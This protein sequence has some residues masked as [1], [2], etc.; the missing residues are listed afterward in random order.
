MIWD[1]LQGWWQGVKGKAREGWD[2]LTDHDLHGG[3]RQPVLAGRQKRYG[4]ERDEVF[5]ATLTRAGSAT[6]FLFQSF[7]G[8]VLAGG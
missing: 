2:K 6:S 8:W 7:D 1:D 5:R 4:E 3:R